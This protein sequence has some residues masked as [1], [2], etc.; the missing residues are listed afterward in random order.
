MVIDN[1]EDVLLN[2]NNPTK[3]VKDPDS[4]NA[5]V[6]EF[7]EEEDLEIVIAKEHSNQEAKTYVVCLDLKNLEATRLMIDVELLGDESSLKEVGQK[8]KLDLKRYFDLIFQVSLQYSFNE[9]DHLVVDG[10]EVAVKVF[11]KRVERQQ[12]ITPKNCS[13]LCMGWAPLPLDNGSG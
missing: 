6:I 7:T 3:R 13:R 5:L 9:R 4:N 2:L 10:D 1:G 11:A 12:V 8:G